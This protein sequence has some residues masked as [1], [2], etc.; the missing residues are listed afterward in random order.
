MGPR[1][2]KL[3]LQLIPQPLDGRNLRSNKE[4]LGPWGWKKL[5]QKIKK[6]GK[7]KCELCGSTERLQ[8]HEVWE[9]RDKPHIPVAKLLR[10]EIVCQKCHHVI[11]WGNTC[12]LFTEGKI[13]KAAILALQK[14]FRE[15][16]DCTQKDFAAHIES[17]S[18]VHQKLSIK[19]KWR[20]DW[21]RFNSLVAEEKASRESWAER[22]PDH[23]F[24]FEDDP[25][26]ARPTGHVCMAEAAVVARYDA[27]ERP[28]GNPGA[29]HQAPAGGVGTGRVGI[30]RDQ[31]ISNIDPRIFWK[32]FR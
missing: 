29:V 16:N 30:D 25:L 4:G 22:N 21:G 19:K 13:K 8:G 20:I 6:A 10:V 26:S 2:F 28:A 24:L 15:V 17:A 32:L 5:C 14:H 1:R 11:H 23:P 9:Y 3:R 27:G 7:T 31:A 18:N 12:R